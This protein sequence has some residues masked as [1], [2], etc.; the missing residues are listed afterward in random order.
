[1]ITAAV[2]HAVD[3][4]RRASASARGVVGPPQASRTP[5]DQP[6]AGA[7]RARVALLTDALAQG[8]MTSSELTRQAVDRANGWPGI[9]TDLDEVSPRALECAG[10]VD[11]RRG[12]G[13]E[14][15]GALAGVPVTVKDSIDVAGLVSGQ[16]GSLGRHRATTDS[17]SWSR[18]DVE[19]SVLIGHTSMHELAWGL[20]TPGCPNPWGAGL[21]PGGS[22]GGAAASVAAG[23]V[24]IA[25]GSDT[26][27]SIRV[28]AA[29]C[30][31]AGLRPTHGVPTMQG[32][33]PLAPSLDT[34]GAL[35]PTAADCVLAHELMSGPGAASPVELDGLRVGVLAG[36]QG[37]VSDGVATAIADACTVLREQ[38]VQITEVELPH[39]RLA[40]SIAYVLM[41]I[42]SSR[43]WL[44][45]A[46]RQATDVGRHVLQQLREGGRIDVPGGPYE[47]ARALAL[48]LRVQAEGAL[49]SNK[50]AA[51]ISP[52]TA[53]TGVR[54]DAS[55]V[56]VQGRDMAMAD[57]LSRYTA[58]ASVT[59]LPA[60]SVPAGLESGFPV[61]VQIIG[62]PYDERLLASLA[63]PIEQG[64]GRVVA[65]GR[66]ALRPP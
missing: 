50:L 22:S 16:G 35:A 15:L 24:A 10:E 31:V 66:E 17:G 38:G 18:L 29:L 47:L 39:A 40:P 23:I 44:A 8:E 55:T 59:G 1:V 49:R 14:C 61:A 41:L 19:G 20:T 28:P 58:L 57:A 4:L 37:R 27:G 48:T 21:T 33:A 60:L 42:E 45:K 6:L 34:V 30:G 53:A 3:A 11:R 56:A 9:V 62:A 13:G 54:A 2:D 63:H 51:L 7:L 46:E 36:W 43:L 12:K 52:V 64:P 32:I 25:I 26:G 5:T 65:A